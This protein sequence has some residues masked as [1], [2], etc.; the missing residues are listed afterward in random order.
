[1]QRATRQDQEA[2][3]KS[4]RAAAEQLEAMRGTAHPAPDAAPGFC[5]DVNRRLMAPVPPRIITV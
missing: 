2:A 1:M 4:L 5:A 3:R